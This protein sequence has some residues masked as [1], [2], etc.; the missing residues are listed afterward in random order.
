MVTTFIQPYT[1]V[2]ENYKIKN[3]IKQ[4]TIEQETKPSVHKNVHCS[5]VYDFEKLQNKNERNH[6]T[7]QH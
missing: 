3:K 2:P 6:L 4:P 5:V 7:I 1:L